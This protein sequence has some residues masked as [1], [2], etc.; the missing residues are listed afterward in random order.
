VRRLIAIEPVS[1]AKRLQ[2]PSELKTDFFED[3]LITTRDGV[4]R[5]SKCRGGIE[6]L[7]NLLRKET[8]LQSGAELNK[9]GIDLFESRRDLG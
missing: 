5:P 4:A 1:G 3:F 2:K 6:R 7:K 8:S 9:F